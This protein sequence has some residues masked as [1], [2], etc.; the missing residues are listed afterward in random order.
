MM[1]FPFSFYG[2]TVGNKGF[3]VFPYRLFE[4]RE[5]F[6]NFPVSLP[7]QEEDDA[8]KGR[9]DSRKIMAINKE[10][11]KIIGKLH[12]SCYCL[13]ATTF[14]VEVIAAPHAPTFTVAVLPVE[15]VRPDAPMFGLFGDAARKV[16]IG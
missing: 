4:A 16:P 12:V 9:I 15:I 3:L 1:L 10:I 7:C 13:E 14:K 6:D 8:D 5:L 11:V 2:D